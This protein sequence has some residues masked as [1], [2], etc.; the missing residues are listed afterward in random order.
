MSLLEDVIVIIFELSRSINSKWQ[1]LGGDTIPFSERHIRN[2]LRTIRYHTKQ[3][4][5]SA[6]GYIS[7]PDTDYPVSFPCFPQVLAGK[8]RYSY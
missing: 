7:D 1:L 6:S 5:L 4:G 2:Y 3:D 8:F